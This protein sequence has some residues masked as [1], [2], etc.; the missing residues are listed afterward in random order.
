MFLPFYVAMLRPI[1]TGRAHRSPS[2]LAGAGHNAQNFTGT[3]ESLPETLY[4][5]SED[6]E[7][8]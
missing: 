4:S 7:R 1:G 6:E 3:G 5:E 8:K 2:T